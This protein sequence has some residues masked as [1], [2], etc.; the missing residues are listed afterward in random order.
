VYTLSQTKWSTRDQAEASIKV[1]PKEVLTS[2][3]KIRNMT[4][5]DDIH[6]TEFTAMVKNIWRSQAGEIAAVK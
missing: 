3:K 2:P 5:G 6:R 4:E 1:P